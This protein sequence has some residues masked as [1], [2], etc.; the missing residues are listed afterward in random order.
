MIVVS[1]IIICT[2]STLSHALIWIQLSF[3]YWVC[4][5][6]WALRVNH[7][8]LCHQISILIGWLGS[9]I[10]LSS[11]CRSWISWKF[12]L[13]CLHFG[14]WI[15]LWSRLNYSILSIFLCIYYKLSWLIQIL[16]SLPDSSGFHVINPRIT[17]ITTSIVVHILL[18][19]IWIIKLRRL[20]TISIEKCPYCTCDWKSP[21]SRREF[22]H[23]PNY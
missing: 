16:R 22:S 4:L 3:N 1:W 15:I 7:I 14:H 5:F 11:L 21:L 23:F 19:Q 9:Y 20:W 12:I 6:D 10:G 8:I 18:H 13:I 2:I 17:S